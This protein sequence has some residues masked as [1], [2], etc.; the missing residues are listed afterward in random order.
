[1]KI[2]PFYRI[3]PQDWLLTT[4]ADVAAAQRKA[5]ENPQMNE[6]DNEEYVRQWVLHE[7]IE[8]YGYPK[9]LNTARAVRGKGG[10][11]N[12]A[13]QP[14]SRTRGDSRRAKSARP[15]HR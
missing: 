5:I 3:Q 6:R 8:T 14:S 12:K 9:E 13:L 1:M 10:L 11:P 4:N 7:L 15:A 2:R